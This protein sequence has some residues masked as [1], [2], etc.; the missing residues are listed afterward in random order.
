MIKCDERK[1]PYKERNI[2]TFKLNIYVSP[3]VD[4]FPIYQ[5]LN[6]IIWFTNTHS[7]YEE[8]ISS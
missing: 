5:Q 4:E 8:K 7:R 1:T 3:L 2:G 6:L